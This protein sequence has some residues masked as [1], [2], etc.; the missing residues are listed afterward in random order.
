[1][2]RKKGITALVGLVL[3]AVTVM[4]VVDPENTASQNK[5]ITEHDNTFTGESE[6]WT[7]EFHVDGK[8]ILYKEDGVWKRDREAQSEFRLTYKGP[9][10]ELAAAKEMSYEYK[11]PNSGTKA[12]MNF[13]DVPPK[14]KVFI[15]HG[16][17]LV[18]EDEI[19]EVR[20]QW[21]GHTEEFTLQSAE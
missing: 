9:L 1:M 7:V 11:T 15:N 4:L 16:H 14:D 12:E 13:H 3:L 19:I 20:V 8:E 6:H 17:K 21:G 10:E 5:D 2:D 18:R